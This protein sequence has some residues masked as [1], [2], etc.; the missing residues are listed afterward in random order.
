MKQ[1]TRLLVLSF[2]TTPLFFVSKSWAWGNLGHK[3]SAQIAWD[4]MDAQ[5]RSKVSSI[6]QKKDFVESATWADQARSQKP[7]KYTI[8]YHFEKAPDGFNYL[9]NLKQQDAETRK[10]GGLIQ[11]LFVAEDILTRPDESAI[12]KENAMKFLI[13]FIGDIHQP[14]HTGRPE[15]NGA[16]KIKVTWLGEKLSLHHVWDTS[17]ILSGHSLL[18][19]DKKEEQ[20]VPLFANYLV[21]KFKVNFVNLQ[22]L[23][24]YDIWMQES[25]ERRKEG[26]DHKDDSEKSYTARFSNHVDERIYLA[27]VRIAY[28]VKRI[29]QIQATRETTESLLSLKDS[30]VGIVGNFLEF[31]SLKPKLTSAKPS[32][33]LAA[34]NYSNGL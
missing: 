31:V 16:T 24:N 30:I 18:L 1:G 2:L 21:K 26:Y 6:L 20:Q 29:L 5:T 34:Q 8:W 11:A 17:I 15:D 25:M 3:T 9:D 28:T 12:D 22:S 19:E 27:G 33:Y 32:E 14:F 23:A 7:W 4:L 10:N 13:H